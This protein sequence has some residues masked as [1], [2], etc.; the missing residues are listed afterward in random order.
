MPRR[1]L[2]PRPQT[3]TPWLCQLE[4]PWPLSG[5]H[6]PGKGVSCAGQERL[7]NPSRRH[8]GIT[9]ELGP[10]WRL[11]ATPSESGLSGLGCG[12]SFQSF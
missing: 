12:L 9:W 10:R 2:W 8:A 1:G 5:P 6:S 4:Q 3:F 11:T 7:L